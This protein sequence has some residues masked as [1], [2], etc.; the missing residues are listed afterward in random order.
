MGAAR[1]RA[2]WPEALTADEQVDVVHICVPNL[3]P[4]SPS[5][6]AFAAGKR[7]ICEK[8]LAVE[9]ASAEQLLS[10]QSFLSFGK[11]TFS[12]ELFR[13]FDPSHVRWLG[14]D[15]VVDLVP[16]VDRVEHAQA[17]D[18]QIFPN[19][20]YRFGFFGKAHRNDPWDTGWWRDR[21]PGLGEVNRV[22]VIDILYAG[23]FEGTVSV[24]Q[25]D[26]AWSGTPQKAKGGPAIAYRAVPL[27]I[28]QEPPTRQRGIND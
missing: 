6:S 24:E 13:N 25:E 22:S 14:I 26:P 8:P 3:L 7:V 11:W 16:N 2:L 4:V 10:A 12:S 18:I 19:Q 20:R 21:L 27:L 1:A 9:T 5:L 23:G 28:I 17:R 15:P